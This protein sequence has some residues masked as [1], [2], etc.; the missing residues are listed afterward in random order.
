MSPGRESV[1]KNALL[2]RTK[3]AEF[4]RLWSLD[5]LGLEERGEENTVHQVFKEQL[6]RSPE[7]WYEIG[8]IWET[9][10]RITYQRIREQSK[11]SKTGREI[12]ETAGTLSKI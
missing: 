4:E 5:V 1:S 11:T 3:E 12:R 7:G 6:E 9:G 10:S 8:L 2:T